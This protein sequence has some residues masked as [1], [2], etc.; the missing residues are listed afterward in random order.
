M[1]RFIFIALAMCVW[2]VVATILYP[3]WIDGLSDVITH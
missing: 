2:L 1:Q 3:N